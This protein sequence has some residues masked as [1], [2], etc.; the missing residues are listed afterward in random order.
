MCVFE[1]CAENIS[2]P[3]TTNVHHIYLCAI[4]L[5][6]KLGYVLYP[7]ITFLVP[8]VIIKTDVLVVS[9]L[10]ILQDLL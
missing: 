2:V 9:Y 1:D 10:I 6:R 8:S 4:Y 3:G 7:R 5:S